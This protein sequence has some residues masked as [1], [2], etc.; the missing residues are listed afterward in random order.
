MDDPD[1]NED[2]PDGVDP[3]DVYEQDDADV[4]YEDDD[5]EP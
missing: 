3:D 5:Y 1:S 2:Y 4:S